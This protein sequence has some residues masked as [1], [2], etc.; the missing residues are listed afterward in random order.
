MVV[1]VNFLMRMILVDM[2]KGLRLRNLSQETNYTM[3]AIFVGQ[4]VNTA[5]LLLFNSA[6][7]ADIDGGKGPLSAIFM[8][9]DRTDFDVEWYRSV[10]QILM[11]TMFSIAIWPLI[12][13]VMFYSIMNLTRWMDRSWGNDTFST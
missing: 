7:F 1:L 10:G 2:I 3:V 6:N 13:F 12:E 9:G 5:L 11:K 8:V 4:F